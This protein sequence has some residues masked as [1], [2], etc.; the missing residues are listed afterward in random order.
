MLDAILTQGG[1]VH[2]LGDRDRTGQRP[3]LCGRRAI[4]SPYQA[5]GPG[6]CCR[7]CAEA[8]RRHHRRDIGARMVGSMGTPAGSRRG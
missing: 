1:T 5:E 7:S 3:T 6:E 2:L 4:G 8:Y